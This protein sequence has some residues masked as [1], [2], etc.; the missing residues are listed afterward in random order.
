MI[1]VEG[2]APSQWPM[3]KTLRCRALADAPYAFSTTLEEAQCRPD[4]EWISSASKMATDEHTATFIAYHNDEPC[5]MMSCYTTGEQ[6][7]IGNIVS[8]WVAPEVRRLKVALQLLEVTRNWAKASKA[9]VLY[10]WVAER[11]LPARRFWESNG[12]QYTGKCETF[13]PD[14]SQRILLLAQQLP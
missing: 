10:A 6:N 2:I 14:P 8:L 3:L 11:N 4:E 12:F 9:Q 5:G 13:K 1:R 7:E